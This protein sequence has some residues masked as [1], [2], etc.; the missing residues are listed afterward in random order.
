MARKLHKAISDETHTYAVVETA[1]SSGGRQWGNY[2]HLSTV[3]LANEH[4]DTLKSASKL[5][6]N[7]L[8]E[9]IESWEANAANQ[10]PRSGYGKTINALIKELPQH[11]QGEVRYDSDV[12]SPNRSTT[13]FN[14]VI[15]DIKTLSLVAGRREA[16][17]AIASQHS[18]AGGNNPVK[19]NARAAERN[20]DLASPE[21]VLARRNRG[22]VM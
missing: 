8:V 17:A 21:E 15:E 12:L 13:E 3:K 6:G 19:D 2:V 20:D 11:V 4:I 18:T 16:L 7:P 5:R 14:P 10:G 9:V 22:R 1:G